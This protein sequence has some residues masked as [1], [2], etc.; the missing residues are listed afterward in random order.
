MNNGEMGVDL[1]GQRVET[2]TGS[3]ASSFCHWK[4]TKYDLHLGK[5]L[6]IYL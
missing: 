6:F 3:S 2:I 5:Y 1:R 4:R